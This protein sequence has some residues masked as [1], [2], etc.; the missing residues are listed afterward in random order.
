MVEVPTQGSQPSDARPEQP[1]LGADEMFC[2]SC[3]GVIK[4]RAEICVKCGVRVTVPA[5]LQ[6]E[7][8]APTVYSPKSRLV[9]GLLGILLGAIGVHRF[10]LGNVGIGIVQI[11]VT[12]VTLGIGSLWG[13]VEGIIIIAGGD[14]KDARGRPLK[15][16]GM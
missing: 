5:Y 6:S 7:V 12:I 9:A 2:S 10:Y 8:S 14:W 3:G 11:I 15:K 1:K 16:Y 13:F 4:K